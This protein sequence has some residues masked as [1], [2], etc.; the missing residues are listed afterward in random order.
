MNQVMTPGTVCCYTAAVPSSTQDPSGFPANSHEEIDQMSFTGDLEH[1]PIV[2]V[3]QLMNSS[4]KSGILSVK[5]KK[6]E[7]QLVFKDGY[8]VSASH[9]NNS[10]RIGQILVDMSLISTEQLEAGLRKQQADGGNRKPLVITLI[11]MGLTKEEH[12]HKGLQ[13]LIEITLVEILTWKTGK[14]T[15]EALS[16]SVACDFRYYP[17]KMNHEINLNTQS[18]LMDALRIFDE[19]MR[20]GLIQDERDDDAAFDDAF[21]EL[22]S[23]DVLGLDEIDH[24]SAQLPKAFSGFT[25]LDPVATER[26]TLAELAPH[27]PAADLDRIAVYLAKHARDPQNPKSVNEKKMLLVLLSSDWLL[28][29]ALT[30]VCSGLPIGVALVN[31]AA[32]AEKAMAPA[33]ADGRACCLVLDAPSASGN[34][35]PQEPPTIF[36]AIRGR[37]PGSIRIQ[38]ALPNDTT[39]ALLAYRSGAR[40]VIPRPSAGG[41]PSG[42]AG[43]FIDLLETLPSYLL[44]C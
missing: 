8:I 43:E 30:T 21:S 2:D 37:Y 28:G 31:T 3:I 38:L 12:A 9:L 14:F 29:H 6:G 16:H 24:I 13:K 32:E 22:L 18:I 44:G 19:K 33:T 5:G 40:A 35:H 1:L 17:E 39:L 4:R 10:T 27:L 26:R 20:D 42:F 41:N 11:E 36:S 34:N 25:P 15:L 23:E 7:S